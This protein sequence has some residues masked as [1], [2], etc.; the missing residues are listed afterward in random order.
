MT[1]TTPEPK[2]IL[3]IDASGYARRFYPY[4][5]ESVT[6]KGIS[7]IARAAGGF[8]F[9]VQQGRARYGNNLNGLFHMAQGQGQ[10]EA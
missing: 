8:G 7:E 5:K 2:K 10:G 6:P 1:Y 4:P 3:V 9:I